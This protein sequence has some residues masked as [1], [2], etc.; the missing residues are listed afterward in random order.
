MKFKFLKNLNFCVKFQKILTKSKKDKKFNT[1]LK[2]KYKKFSKIE[3]ENLQKSFL[4][5]T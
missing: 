5:F 4:L 3:R 1:I 2:Y